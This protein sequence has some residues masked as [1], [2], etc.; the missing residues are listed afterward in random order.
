LAAVAVTLR[1]FSNS[2][3]RKL[4]EKDERLRRAMGVDRVPHRAWIGRRLTGLAPEAER[5]IALLGD[6]IVEEVQPEAGPPKPSAIAG[7]ADVPSS[8]PEVAPAGSAER[9]CARGACATSTPNRSGPRAALAEGFKATGS[10]CKASPSHIP[11]RFSPLGART[12]RTKR[13]L[14]S[15]R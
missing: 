8:R 1:A 12:T 10:S 14:R 5:Q 11:S 13:T 4:P 15:R 2:E 7:R 6:Q 3:L 9:P